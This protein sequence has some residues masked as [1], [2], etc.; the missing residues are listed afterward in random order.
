MSEDAFRKA[1]SSAQAA[2][3]FPGSSG[4]RREGTQ[5][6]NERETELSHEAGGAA[7]TPPAAPAEPSDAEAGTEAGYLSLL[8]SPGFDLAVFDP[9][10]IL[11][12]AAPTAMAT[13]PLVFD[14]GSLVSPRPTCYALLCVSVLSSLVGN[15]C[16]LVATRELA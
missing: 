12:L 15:S 6:T 5:S 11:V 1:I 14:T 7:A 4:A 16:A 10:V 3:S 9:F 2:L 8:R 13:G